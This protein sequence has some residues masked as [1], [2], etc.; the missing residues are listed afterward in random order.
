MFVPE[1]PVLRLSIAVARS[2][3]LD[4]KVNLEI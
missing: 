3:V 4:K 2:G 1:N